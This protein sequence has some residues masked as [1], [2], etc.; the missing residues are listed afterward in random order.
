MNIE[1]DDVTEL[2][3]WALERIKE[4]KARVA[5]AHDKKVQTKD[6]QVGDWVWKL[7][8][9]TELRIRLMENGHLLGMVHIV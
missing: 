5:K 9:H 7:C 3:L 4:N 1:T 2:R 6:F 8:Y